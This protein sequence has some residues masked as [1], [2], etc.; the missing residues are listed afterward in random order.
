MGHM[1]ESFFKHT[2]NHQLWDNVGKRH[3]LWDILLWDKPKL[4]CPTLVFPCEIGRIFSMAGTKRGLIVE[5]HSGWRTPYIFTMTVGALG[6]LL[7][8]YSQFL[9]THQLHFSSACGRVLFAR[10]S[11]LVQMSS[12][13]MLANN[14]FELAV[15]Y[16][17]IIGVLHLICLPN[18]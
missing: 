12:T 16:G 4:M 1:S 17:F 13:S 3:Q 5:R 6:S 9:V 15:I 8:Q 18:M 7:D 2:S 11:L 10:N 14:R